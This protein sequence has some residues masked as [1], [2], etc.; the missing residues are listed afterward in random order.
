MN[1]NKTAD[2]T[3]RTGLSSLA[4]AHKN[5]L[6]VVG[7]AILCLAADYLAFRQVQDQAI[8]NDNNLTGLFLVIFIP[9]TLALPLLWYL[10]FVRKIALEAV[11]VTTILAFGIMAMFVR[12]PYTWFDE[13]DHIYQALY[14]SDV[15]LGAKHDVTESGQL[16]WTARLDDDNISN[17][18]GSP[19]F[20]YHQTAASDYRYLSEHFFETEQFPGETTTLTVD[21]TG[22]FYQY[23]PATVGVTIGKLLHLGNVPTIYLGRL[24]SLLFYAYM[25]YLTIRLAPRQFK[26][27][28]ALLALTPFY[29][30]AAGTFSYDNMLNVLAFLLVAYV[31]RLIF[32]VENV[33]WR[34]VALL[35][36][37]A[38][39]LAPLKFLYFPLIFLPALIP[40]HKWP[41]PRFRLYWCL[42]I[43]LL[44]L[45]FAGILAADQMAQEA[46]KLSAAQDRHPAYSDAYTITSFLG[47]PASAARLL[48]ESLFVHLQLIVIPSTS[49]ITCDRLPDWANYLVFALLLLSVQPTKDEQTLHFRRQHRIALLATAA[50]VYLLVLLVALTWTPVG[51]VIIASV[52]GRYFI[53]IVPLIVLASYNAIKL[54]GGIAK[55]ALYIFCSLN[56]IGIIMAFLAV[57]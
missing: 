22:V 2:K 47:H 30:S 54:T 34:D 19:H 43:A 49:F 26:L 48:A 14:F 31:L 5:K 56:A 7:I 39:L 9:L 53:P 21:R 36:T 15:A 27:L 57:V 51:S 33:R 45:A 25:S 17:T 1:P 18:D 11:M 35:A 24:F 32:D 46:H 52:Q 4:S 44:A 10:I 3:V 37:V 41:L 38:I 23:L 12:T 42:G 28:F 50:I 6:I 8:T 13:N 55:I 40:K 20:N 16:S 29:L